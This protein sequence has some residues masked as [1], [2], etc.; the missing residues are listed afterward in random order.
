VRDAYAAPVEDDDRQWDA[1]QSVTRDFIGLS[2]AEAEQ[3]AAGL[4]LH[5]TVLD[6]D[7]LGKEPVALAFSTRDDIIVLWVHGGVVT[8]AEPH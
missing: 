6:G 4:G 5:P 1:I 7:V 2:R 3:L 8:R